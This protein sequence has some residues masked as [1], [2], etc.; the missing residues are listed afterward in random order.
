VG[1]AV[2]LGQKSLAALASVV[3]VAVM[4]EGSEVVLFLFGIAAG[5]QTSQ[6]SMLIGGI[7]GL[8][9]AAAVSWVLYR[10][11]L[12]IPLKS[13]FAVTNVLIALLAAGMAATAVGV[14]QGADML[15]WWNEQLWNSGWL[16]DDGGMA[17]RTLHA[18][19]GY[20]ATPTG[21]QLVA[22]A[23]TLVMM[24][25]LTRIAGRNQP[26][27]MLSAVTDNGSLG[28]SAHPR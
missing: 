13:L 28:A 5:S 7:C 12:I 10:G 18:L 27:R 1:D 15:P 25:A 4:R 23:A 26:A 9:A 21:L 17:G 22:W 2:R 16:L 20:T 3:A 24:W 19:V 8:A 6:L 14:L 11:L